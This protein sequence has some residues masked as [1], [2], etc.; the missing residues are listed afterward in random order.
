MDPN[1]IAETLQNDIENGTLSPGTVLKQERL[2]ERFGVSRQPVRQALERLLVN[3]LLTKRS[4]RSL[5]VNGLS[6]DEARDL[7][8]I[9]IS[10][11][12][13]ALILSIPHL[14]QNDLRKAIRLND[15]LF[16]EE[17]PAIIEELDIA[18]HQTLYA[19]CGND[20]LLKMIAELRGEARR[21]YHRQPPGSQARK[22]FY[23]EH[24]DLLAVCNRGDVN[25]AIEIIENHIGITSRQLVQSPEN[26]APQ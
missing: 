13:T 18:F 4:D 15:D 9:R 3:G 23:E 21:S 26:G 19:P 5:A 2:A 25:K 11:E 24:N 22:V 1:R 17:N 7:S 10:L 16:E 12:S 8:Q 6:A 14:S 20:R